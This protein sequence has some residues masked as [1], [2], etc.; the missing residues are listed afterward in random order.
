LTYLN[1]L[2][3]EVVDLMVDRY[4]SVPHPMTHVILYTL[5]GAISRVHPDTTAVAYRDA[6]HAFLVVG[7]WDQPEAD[8]HNIRWVREFLNAIQ[9]FSPGGFYVNYD[10]DVASGR[11]QAAYGEEKYRRLV[12]LKRRYDPANLFRLNQNIRP[13]G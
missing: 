9:P 12:E 8:R 10:T 4:A 2:P 1:D 13:G 5:G 7:M 11:I 3:E 6:S